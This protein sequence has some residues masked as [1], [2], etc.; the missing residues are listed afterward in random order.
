M[1]TT[2]NDL[3]GQ[4]KF[5]GISNI[6]VMFTSFRKAMKTVFKVSRSNRRGCDAI[7]SFAPFL[8]LMRNAMIRHS[9]GQ[10]G[11]HSSTSIMELP[12]KV[13]LPPGF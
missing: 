7:E 3:K 11:R 8:F 1:N 13:R 9:I 5:I 4:L 12:P 10:T 6:D 2:P